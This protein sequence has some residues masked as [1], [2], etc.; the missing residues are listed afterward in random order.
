MF[1]Y[2]L[3][4][5]YDSEIRHHFSELL[6]MSRFHLGE[7]KAGL[8]GMY[9]YVFERFFRGNGIDFHEQR[10]NKSEAKRS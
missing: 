2:A 8:A 9:A 7:G 4:L 5:L 3:D 1:V 10:S 6:G